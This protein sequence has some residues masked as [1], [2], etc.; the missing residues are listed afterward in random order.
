MY[1]HL[2]NSPT[3]FQS[4]WSEM[5]FSS[6]SGTWH[7]PCRVFLERNSLV[8]WIYYW[9]EIHCQCSQNRNMTVWN[10]ATILPM[11]SNH[12]SFSFTF[13]G[14]SFIK[15]LRISHNVLWPYLHH[16]PIPPISSFSTLISET[17]QL[18]TFLFMFFFIFF[19]LP[20]SLPSCFPSFFPSFFHSVPHHSW[21]QFVV[22]NCTWGVWPA[23]ECKCTQSGV[24]SYK[25]SPCFLAAAKHQ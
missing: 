18:C 20:S 22:P 11:L 15:I 10:H 3:G 17:M 13:K 8:C 25:K 9:A 7:Y 2:I 14:S 1:L 24:I 6:Q 21:V 4:D 16:P 19:F 12:V 5:L 23:L